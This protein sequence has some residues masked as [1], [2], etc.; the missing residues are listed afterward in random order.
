[1]TNV[2]LVAI[3]E[4]E[5]HV[6][7]KKSDLQ[8]FKE[9]AKGK[10][11]CLDIDRFV[12]Y[13]TDFGDQDEIWNLWI[14]SVIGEAEL[15]GEV[16]SEE[17]KAD[18]SFV[19]GLTSKQAPPTGFDAGG[20]EWRVHNWGTPLNFNNPRLVEECYDEENGVLDYEFETFC[21]PPGPV[22]EKM[23]KMFPNLRFELR[24][25][26]ADREFNGILVISDG[27]VQLADRAKYYGDRGG[28]I[29]LA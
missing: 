23:G 5:L 21:S 4:C 8:R 18:P 3:C 15:K 13:P 2:L 9:S 24:Y 28:Y 1:M 22:I 11:G 14:D 29:Q 12:P 10:N 17:Q 27:K 7:G 25:F 26:D 19:C 20:Y 6:V 16:L